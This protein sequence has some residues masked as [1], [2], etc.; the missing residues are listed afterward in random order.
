[1]FSGECGGN[2]HCLVQILLMSSPCIKVS[3]REIHYNRVVWLLA[4]RKSSTALSPGVK[5]PSDTDPT[6]GFLQAEAFGNSP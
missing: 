4:E 3:I 1:M 2:F 6:R 5:E